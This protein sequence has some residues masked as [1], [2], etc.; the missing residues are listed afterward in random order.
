MRTTAELADYIC[1]T[2]YDDIAPAV[3]GRA[4][5]LSL[6]SLGSAL[7][8]S[9]MAVPGLLAD[10]V[11]AA[12][13]PAEAGVIGHGFRTSAELAAAMN[14]SSSHATELE[15]V[16]WPEATYTCFLIPTLFALGEQLHASGRA[17]L[18]SIVLGFEIA[19]R[20]GVIC[21]DAGATAR[22]WLPAS[23]LG[24]VG[25]AAAAAKMLGLTPA[26]THHAIAVAA[27]FGAGLN[28]QTGSGAHVVEAG[29]AGRNGIMA[30]QLARRG[31]T[32]NPTIMEGR[33][34]Y[35]DA[36]AG[37]PELDFPLG[38][39][40]DFRLLAVGMKKYP[41]CYLSQRIVD[42]VLALVR[43]HRIE[44]E[45]VA[46]V[47]VEVNS[48]FPQII[49]YPEPADV[50]QAR[51]SL[52]HIVAAAL[53]GEKMNFETF[54]A[55]K[56]RD[57]RLLAQRAKVRM[58][59][60]PEWGAAQLS[61]GN[62]VTIRLHNGEIYHRDCRTAHGDAAD[63][64]SRDEVIGNFRD[65]TAGLLAESRRQQAVDTLCD[66][67]RAEDVAPLLALLTYPEGE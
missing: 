65:C 43:E 6:R 19:A 31:L 15:D 12:A 46:E 35:W 45:A 8:G 5:E 57:P 3:I 28:R 21:S 34:G 30:A 55:A 4:E 39:G 27:S 18:E 64:L 51:F 49:K 63:P 32:G 56:L 29:F 2:G 26:Q 23:H 47:V 44:P 36:L 41:C 13:A 33:A 24:T 52:P 61:P 7:L 22:G 38:R 20:P 42:G 17:V 60:H 54:T 59:V 58:Q 14:C 62:P 16:S 53:C 10:Y 67:R 66:L 25:V 1:S 48:T 9:R 50:E 37:Q 11:R 40:D